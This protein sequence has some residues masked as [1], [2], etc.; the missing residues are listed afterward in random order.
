MTHWKKIKIILKEIRASII[1]DY[2]LRFCV[3]AI[4]LAI[5]FDLTILL[6]ALINKILH[7]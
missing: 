4:M 3:N 2:D 7:Q 1:N 5:A 6:F